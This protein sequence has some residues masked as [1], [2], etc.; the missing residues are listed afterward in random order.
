MAGCLFSGAERAPG[1][2]STA[3]KPATLFHPSPVLPLP[4]LGS[5]VQVSLP[6]HHRWSLASCGS[7]LGAG[8]TGCPR[9]GAHLPKP[10]ALETLAPSGGGSGSTASRD[11][12]GLLPRRL[13]ALGAESPTFNFTCKEPRQQRLPWRGIQV[14]PHAALRSSHPALCGEPSCLGSLSPS[15]NGAARVETCCARPLPTISTAG[16]KQPGPSQ[17]IC[18]ATHAPPTAT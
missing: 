8:Q 3:L 17:G 15:P 11:E 13:A 14:P 2:P 4:R 7:F 1:A 18:R 12:P 10:P 16:M 9:L 5:V 6:R